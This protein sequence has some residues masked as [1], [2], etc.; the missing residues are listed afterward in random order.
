MAAYFQVLGTQTIDSCPSFL[1]FSEK[2]RYMFNCG[3][4]T[5]RFSL[6]HKIRLSK[7]GNFFFT[8]MDW[9]CVGGFPGMILTLADM[10]LPKIRAHGP[11]L[12]ELLHATRFFV[13]RNN[14][15]VEASNIH[16]STLVYEDEF[17]KCFSVLIAADSKQRPTKRLKTASE[18][19]VRTFPSEAVCYVCKLQ[20]LP[21]KFLPEKA[22]ALGV[23]P[24]PLYGKLVRGEVVQNRKGEEVHPD[25][26]LGPSQPGPIVLLIDCPTLEFLPSLVNHTFWNTFPTELV[27]ENTLYF[28]HTC[29]ASVLNHTLYSTWLSQFSAPC[30]HVVINESCSH[31]IIYLGSTTNQYLL[32][33]LHPLIFPLPFFDE[34][35]SWGSIPV[36]MQGDCTIAEPLLK[37]ILWPQD[38]RAFVDSSV[39]RFQA[40]GIPEEVTV[41]KEKYLESVKTAAPMSSESNLEII[42]L[43]TG[44]AIPSKYRNVSATLLR[45]GQEFIFFDC[46]EGTLGQL[47]RKFG[48]AFR[49]VLTKLKGVF[50]SHIHAD[51][52]LGLLRLILARENTAE[53][54]LIVGPSVLGKWLREYSQL[55]PLTYSF[56]PCNA[57]LQ[58]R[59]VLSNFLLQTVR[60]IHCEDAYGFVLQIKDIKIVYS[61]DTRPC[62]ELVEEGRD[63]F[64]VIHEATF[65]E[66]L[67]EDA[68]VKKHCT[69]PEAIEVTSRMHAKFAILN[70]FSQ[71]YPKLPMLN[72]SISSTKI[73]VST[74]F[75]SVRLSDLHVLPRMLP[76]LRLLFET[77]EPDPCSHDTA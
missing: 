20:D 70:H 66:E 53:P 27:A 22:K 2:Q 19:N 21:G 24:G 55:Q 5:Q 61:G 60:V 8:R 17:L 37:L 4:G 45:Y 69:I 75:M 30:K 63:A 3:E 12:R 39:P 34:T 41:E 54:L 64:V 76:V 36:A 15:T 57:L 51:H 47:F 25:Q 67:H 31:R 7:V 46:G 56:L 13:R 50:V 23:P 72:E 48:N 18:E 42:C 44:A 11:R 68:V 49:D 38:K 65:D 58:P 28:F 32:N 33:N 40:P 71:R 43:G 14:F 9:E 59:K 10:G 62:P 6:E 74:D 1:L 77:A 29:P 26:C 16:D 35:V 73:A 52:H